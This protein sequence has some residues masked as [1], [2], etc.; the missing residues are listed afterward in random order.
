V[1]N[2]QFAAA[3]FPQHTKAGADAL[4]EALGDVDKTAAQ[5][6]RLRDF[7]TQVADLLGIPSTATD[8]F[9]LNEL[10]AKCRLVEAWNWDHQGVQVEDEHG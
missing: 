8:A 9:V 4:M 6:Q 3:L 5:H 1:S 10:A 2:A 7:R